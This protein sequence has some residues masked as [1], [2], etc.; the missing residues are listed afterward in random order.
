MTLTVIVF[1]HVVITP[2]PLNREIPNHDIRQLKIP[3]INEKK[4]IDLHRND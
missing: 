3:K 2:I 4:I 1:F